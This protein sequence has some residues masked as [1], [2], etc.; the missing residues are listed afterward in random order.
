MPLGDDANAVVARIWRHAAERPSGYRAHRR[1]G[2][3]DFRRTR[4]RQRQSC[5]SAC[6][7]RDR[8]RRLRGHVAASNT[9]VVAALAIDAG[10]GLSGAGSDPEFPAERN[11]FC[12]RDCGTPLVLGAAEALD[13]LGCSGTARLEPEQWRLEDA[14]W[15][16][17]AGERAY[18]MYTSGSTGQPKGV[19]IDRTALR[20]Y[21]DWCLATLPLT[22][23]G[24]PWFSS[25]AFDHSVTVLFPPLLAGETLHILPSIEGGRRLGALLL[26]HPRASFVKITPSH[27]RL[28][29]RDECAALGRMAGM[30]MLGGEPASAE[31]IALLRRDAPDLWVMNHYG[32]TEVTV[33]CATYDVPSGFSGA[34]VPIGRPMPQCRAAIVDAQGREVEDSEPGELIFAGPALARG[35]LG[36][37]DL[38][39]RAFV[40]RKGADGPQR[41][42]RTGDLA[43]RRVDGN[44]ELLGRVDDQIK[45]L[46]HR[47]EPA[48]IEQ[49]I[50]SLPAVRDAAV[51]VMPSKAGPPAVRRRG[52]CDTGFGVR[53]APG[54]RRVSSAAGL[55]QRQS[56]RP[57]SYSTAFP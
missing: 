27:L 34:N 9:F 49:H 3:L 38:T 51:L 55:L 30:I 6:R 17:R 26:S 35:Y 12:L 15:R 52:S 25:V 50:K 48:E 39:S 20:A 10:R 57:F 40:T 24:V 33:G 28:L 45:I 36:R 44:L 23:H 18:V 31:L 5:P 21:L 54:D 41:W 8:A 19:L 37:D 56:R 7:H 32:P 16:P 2:L 14:P 29:T 11:R 4:A 42:Y 1:R 22:G 47:I 43:R 13:A 46:G 53:L